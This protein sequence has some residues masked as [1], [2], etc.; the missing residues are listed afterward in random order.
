MLAVRTVIWLASTYMPD[1]VHGA[2]LGVLLFSLTVAASHAF[3][4]MK[5]TKAI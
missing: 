2:E 1:K 5:A 3:V 4:V